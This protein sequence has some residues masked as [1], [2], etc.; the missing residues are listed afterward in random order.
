MSTP[1]TPIERVK[2]PHEAI[3]DSAERSATSAT[4]NSVLADSERKEDVL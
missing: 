1:C 2:G 4:N 3:R